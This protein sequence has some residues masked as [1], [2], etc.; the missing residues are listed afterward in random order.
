MLKK[1][2]N[3]CNGL[4]LKAWTTVYYSVKNLMFTQVKNMLHRHLFIPRTIVCFTFIWYTFFFMVLSF[5]IF[6]FSFANIACVLHSIMI[7]IRC[8]LI[9]VIIALYLR[10][11]V[12][13]YMVSK[14]TKSRSKPQAFTSSTKWMMTAK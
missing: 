10:F 4:A 6:F 11:Y 8:M 5:Q 7:L 1:N 12:L 14:Q 2:L 3:W 13:G 9:L